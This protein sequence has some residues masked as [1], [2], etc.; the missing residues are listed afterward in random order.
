MKNVR[1]KKYSMKNQNKKRNL[2]EL[3]SNLKKKEENYGNILL[4]ATDFYDKTHV[5]KSRNF[6]S[7]KTQYIK[8]SINDM[9]K[10]D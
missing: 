10:F 1:E 5:E 2:D 6:R 3:F 9:F 7:L 4:V 8:L